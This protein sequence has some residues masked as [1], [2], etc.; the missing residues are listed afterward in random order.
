MTDL[1]QQARLATQRAHLAG[2]EA[3]ALTAHMRTFGM[4]SVQLMAVPEYVATLRARDA[5]RRRY[6]RELAAA[7]LLI[8]HPWPAAERLG[9]EP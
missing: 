1:I 3:A 8:G 7:S 6:W 4:A 2:A 9:S 5:A